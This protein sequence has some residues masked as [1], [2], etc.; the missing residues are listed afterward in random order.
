MSGK[1]KWAVACVVWLATLLLLGTWYWDSRDRVV[2]IAAGPRS[3]EAFGLA[4][5]IA[6]VFESAGLPIRLE[7][8]ET[9]GSAQNV[10]L[11]ESG[12]VGLA[13]I[14][15]NT[16]VRG[17]IAAIASLYFDAFQLVVAESSDIFSFPGLAGHRIA[18]GPNG[19]GQNESFWLLAE[20]YGLTRQMLTAQPISDDA[21]DFGL[22]RGYVDAIFRV[23]RKTASHQM[24]DINMA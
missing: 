23:L 2:A 7:V 22:A 5:T 24:F 4:T 21:A 6:E 8:Y 15:S 18:I 12:Q 13:T 10:Q 20:H 16:T 14:S 17:G 11:L 1:T 3:G 19:S 9:A